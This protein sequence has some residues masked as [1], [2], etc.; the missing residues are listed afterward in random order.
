MAR[1]I[2]VGTA[3]WSI[4]KG[5][6]DG[7]E[8]D[9]THLQRYARQLPCVEINSCFYRPHALQTYERWAAATPDHFRFAVKLPRLITH[10]QKLRR[11]RAPLEQFLAE[12]AG[13]GDKRG[14]ILV[15]LPPSLAFEAR[16]ARRFFD[17]LRAHDH[18]PAVCEPRHESWF[19]A[20][21]DTLLVKHKVARAAVDPAPF[22]GADRPGG[23]RGLSYYRLHG[24][25]RM[26]WSRYDAEWLAALADGL[27][28]IRP[29]G[30]TWAVFDNTATGAA[31][32]NA[33]ELQA[34]LAGTPP[35]AAEAP[36]DEPVAAVVVR[37]RR[38]YSAVRRARA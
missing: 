21:A 10:E 6:P 14:P 17:I 29:L 16:V 35:A 36:G 9:G 25:P 11:T 12:I 19:S 26:Y 18:G 4:P 37:R 22:P 32:E 38:A 24:S 34:L 30:D 13:L 31:I 3:G 23:W 5:S 28:R 1:R 33:V 8:G 20:E 27:Q 2:L 7:F 15:Q